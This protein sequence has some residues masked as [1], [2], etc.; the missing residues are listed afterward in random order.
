MFGLVWFKHGI[1]WSKG[2]KVE[3]RD[4]TIKKPLDD[5]YK[6]TGKRIIR[7][8]RTFLDVIPMHEVLVDSLAVRING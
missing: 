7:E 1:D 2:D 5:D 3:V 6:T 4:I 8:G